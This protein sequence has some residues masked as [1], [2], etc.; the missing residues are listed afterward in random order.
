MEGIV[1]KSNLMLGFS[2]P[3][4]HSI[5]SEIDDIDSPF[6]AQTS[7]C[8]LQT[9]FLE[10]PACEFVNKSLS[11]LWF[12]C[13]PV[14]FFGVTSHRLDPHE[15]ELYGIVG[16]GTFMQQLPFLKGAVAEYVL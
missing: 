5:W 15:S 16:T 11:L 14:S 10:L 12:F 3:L 8:R 9:T 13:L 1:L 4:W 7:L 2:S 6:Y